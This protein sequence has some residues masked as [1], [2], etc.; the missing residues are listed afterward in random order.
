M[1]IFEPLWPW[2]YVAVAASALAVGM[3]LGRGIVD[4]LRSRDLWQP[5]GSTRMIR[6][7]VVCLSILT[8]ALLAAA[9]LNPR[10]IDKPGTTA[11]HLQVAVDVSDS[12]LRAR[13]GWEQVRKQARD[14]IIRG[15][16]AMTSH[17]RRQCTAGILTFRDHTDETWKANPLEEL[18]GAFRQL[19]NSRFASGKGTDIEAGLN[20]AAS[21]L[22]KTGGQGSILLISDGNQTSGDALN[23]ARQLARQGVPIHVYPVTSQGPAVAITDA[24]L[25]RLTHTHVRTF[26]RGLMLNRMTGNKEA[27]LALSKDNSQSLEENTPAKPAVLKKPV[28]LPSGQW[29][30]FRWPVVFDDF[31]LQFIDLSLTPFG[32]KDT[33]RRRFFTYVK[34]PPKILAIGGDNRWMSAVPGDVAEIIPIPPSTR[35]TQRSLQEID[36]VVISGVPAQ[37]LAV[38]SM[39]EVAEA[40]K[41]K[42]MGLMLF[43]GAHSGGD[44]ETETVVMSYKETPLEPLLPVIGGPRPYMDEPP[45]RQVAILFDTSGSMGNPMPGHRLV[46]K[47]D[48]ARE[49]ARY[50]VSALLRPK[51]RLDL[52]TFTTGAGHLVQDRLMDEAG[53]KEALRQIDSISAWGGTNPKRALALIG[54]RQMTACGLIFISDGQFGYV[55][56]RPDCRA[57]VFEIGSS[58]VS[59]SKAMQE[60]AD[61][62]PVE[63]DFDPRAITI[64]YFEPEERLKFFEAGSFT[65]RSMENYLPKNLRLPVPALDLQGSA[66]CYL[67]ENAILNGVRP[68]LTDP[69][70]AFGEGGAGYVGFFASGFPGSWLELKEGQSAIQAW[71]GRLIPFME[72]DRY[73]FKLEDRGDEIEIRISLVAKAGKIPD[74]SRMTANIFF[75]GQESTGIALRPDDIAPGTFHGEIR[76]KRTGEVRRGFLSLRESGTDALPQAQRIPLRIPPK[77]DVT[78]PAT[79]EAY[80]YGQNRRLLEEIAEISGGIYDLPRGTPFFKEKSIPGRGHPLWPYLAAAAV[81]CYLAAIALKRWNS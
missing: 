54:D 37:Q 4:Y 62:I 38:E 18:P 69:I 66:V 12:V 78:P 33:H 16:S 79:S 6:I 53:K 57:T 42:G 56:Y 63:A 20:R 41:S 15:I 45:S 7:A 11:F 24:D 49:I 26:V 28:S 22:E 29:V 17:L 14:K 5:L 77:A 32:D 73:D 51:D 67:K 35:I 25:P 72:R 52:I 13:G 3:M 23:A 74:V 8:A 60:L 19:D 9:A 43:N 48:K 10:L 65:P 31:G 61:P 50:I 75:L 2:T 34:R 76:V 44:D 40:V 36:A 27:E 64:P 71:I 39:F 81:F 1:L 30:R 58:Q 68:K 47:I 21:L 80:S 55:G 59:R 46:S 70:L